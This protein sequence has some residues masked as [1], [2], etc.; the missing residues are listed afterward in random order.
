MIS[1]VPTPQRRGQLPAST[2]SRF[3]ILALT[4]LAGSYYMFNAMLFVLTSRF[5][6]STSER[7]SSCVVS[8]RTRA[9]VETGV[10]VDYFERC[11]RLQMTIDLLL[12]GVALLIFTA[13]VALAYLVHPRV[14]E[15]RARV[16][17][18]DLANDSRRL[19][20]ISAIDS[21]IQT[22]DLNELVELRI[23]PGDMSRAGQAYGRPGRRR[24]ALSLGLL[25]AYATD[26]GLVTA[27]V[28]HEL[29]HIRHRD[30]DMTY[31]A[32]I[33]FWAFLLVSTAPA[34]LVVVVFAPVGIP[35]T[36][37]LAGVFVLA[38]WRNHSGPGCVILRRV[39]A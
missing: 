38:L 20:V 30:I 11:V 13:I 39:G 36:L 12:S 27:V 4:A 3:I 6:M 25:A 37:L 5:G 17:L 14:V 33:T 2:T 29:G 8:A 34:V 19:G 22:S 18:T 15:R 23:C 9:E 16:R 1:G 31:L 26:P 7:L 10:I 21:V 35:A 24:I 28:R 32:V